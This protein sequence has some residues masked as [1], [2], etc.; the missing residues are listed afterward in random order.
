VSSHACREQGTGE[1]A[2]VRLGE[3]D[4]CGAAWGGWGLAGG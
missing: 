2:R 3:K 4:E 1:G